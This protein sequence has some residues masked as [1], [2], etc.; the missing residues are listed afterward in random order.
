[1]NWSNLYHVVKKSILSSDEFPTELLLNTE[2]SGPDS[3]LVFDILLDTFFTAPSIQNK[4]EVRN[5]IDLK[6]YSW[7]N[8]RMYSS[9]QPNII[10]YLPEKN[11]SS[12]GVMVLYK[13]Q[14]ILNDLGFPCRLQKYNHLGLLDKPLYSNH[15]TILIVP[16]TVNSIAHSGKVIQYLGNDIGALPSL[17]LGKNAVCPIFKVKHSS[18]IKEIVDRFYIGTVDFDL[19]NPT[20]EQ[21]LGGV[22]IYLGKYQNQSN[23]IKNLN[24]YSEKF[25]TDLVITRDWPPRKYLPSLLRQLDF[26]VTLDSLSSLN[27]E[28][29]LVGTPV[30]YTE[31]SLQDRNWNDLLQFELFNPLMIREIDFERSKLSVDFEQNLLNFLQLKCKSYRIEIEDSL[32]FSRRLNLLHM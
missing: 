27:L 16:D 4:L 23:F 13:L 19:F 20:R 2:I 24:Y 28:S 10:L 25:S 8:G 1:M 11:T 21:K 18:I 14:Q 17:S 3:K 12:A 32:N 7:D 30:I 15:K 31:V 29:T 26:I 5:K 22:A 9:A 6:S